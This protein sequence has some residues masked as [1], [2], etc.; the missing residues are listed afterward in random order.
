MVMYHKSTIKE[1]ALDCQPRERLIKHGASYL[2]EA[3]LLAIIINTGYKFRG[4]LVTAIDL[5][6]TLL[7]YYTIEEL[8]NVSTTQLQQIPGIGKA[9]AASIKAAFEL[10]R[11]VA[12]ISKEDKISVMSPECAANYLIPLLRFQKQ[13]N[14]VVLLLD[15]KNNV[16]RY[17][18]IH[19]GTVNA[20]IVHPREV[21]KE[22]ISHSAVSCIVAHNHPSGDTT[23]SGE[24]LGVTKRLIEVGQIIGINV[25]DHII[26]GNNDY[27]SFRKESLM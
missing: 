8:I 26:I 2:S 19:L 25:V 12:M 17:S 7:S 14:F 6:N 10:S 1:M 13:E 15:A 21:F 11:R 9:K 5:A 24:D 20:S 3:E 16:I 22:A 18:K 27:F 4:K 23:P